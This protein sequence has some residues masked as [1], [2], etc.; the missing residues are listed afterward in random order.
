MANFVHWFVKDYSDSTARLVP[1]TLKSFVKRT[2]FKI[3]WSS[4]QDPA[5]QKLKGSLSEAPA[6]HFADISGGFNVS[7]DASE[8]GVGSLLA[9][10]SKGSTIGKDLDIVAYY[11]DR[12]SPSQRHHSPTMKEFLAVVW[13]LT[14][15]RLYLRGRNVT[16]CTDHQ[17]LTYLYHMQDTSK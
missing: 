12:F 8:Q 15:R 2:R 3:A 4:A 17:A 14:L 9:Q 1:L 13:A 7:T 16:C 5:F 6:L 11:S 10:P